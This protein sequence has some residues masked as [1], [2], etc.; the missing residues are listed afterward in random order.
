MVASEVL[1]Y[2]VGA[3]WVAQHYGVSPMQVHRAGRDG[4]LRAVVVPNRKKPIVLFDRR[5]LP[6]EFPYTAKELINKGKRARARR[7]AA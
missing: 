7:R 5:L 2:Y 3:S 1:L 6:Y 4:R